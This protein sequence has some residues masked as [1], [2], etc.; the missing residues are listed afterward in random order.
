MRALC[1]GYYAENLLGIGLDD[2]MALGRKNPDDSTEPFN[3][4]Y[5]AM[6]GSGAVNGVSRLHGEV[7]RG[8]F[9]D[10]FPRWPHAEVPVGYVTNGVH[11]PTWDSA[12]ADRSGRRPAGTD[13]WRGTMESVERAASATTRRRVVEDALRR[14]ARELGRDMC[15]ARLPR[16]SGVRGSPRRRSK[17]AEIFDPDCADASALRGALP[18]TSGPICCLRDPE[19]LDPDL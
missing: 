16:S 3:M 15:A 18:P 1:S 9:Q 13:R 8:I 2:L 14:T 19:R 12:A 17:R 10:L 6:R 7:S 4:A 5:L 11:T